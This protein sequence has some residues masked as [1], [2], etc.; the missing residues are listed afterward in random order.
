MG[1]VGSVRVLPK[2]AMSENLMAERSIA[3][4][5]PMNCYSQPTI[6]NRFGGLHLRQAL[7]T[8]H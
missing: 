8:D 5:E 4:F 6:D 3:H 1:F 2:G 7:T